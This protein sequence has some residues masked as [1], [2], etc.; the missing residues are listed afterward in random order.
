MVIFY[1]NVVIKLLITTTRLNNFGSVA[2]KIK[3][4][5]ILVHMVKFYFNVVIK[6]LII[7]VNMVIFYFY[8]VMK[9]FKILVH[10]DIFYLNV[11]IKLLITTTRL[12]NFGSVAKQK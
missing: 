7:L 6:L 11:V 4:F 1:F 2:K 12:N 10:M 5:N 9:L 8:V 3:L